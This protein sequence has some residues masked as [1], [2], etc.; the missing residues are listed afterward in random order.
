MIKVTFQIKDGDV[1]V[2]APYAKTFES[3]QDMYEYLHDQNQHPW[4]SIQILRK[5]QV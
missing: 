1:D 3:E 5:E 4:L 2:D